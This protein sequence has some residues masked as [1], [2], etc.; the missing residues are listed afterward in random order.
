M[1]GTVLARTRV[2]TFLAAC[3]LCVSGAALA[4]GNHHAVDDAA[5]LSPGQCETEGWFE[6]SRSGVKLTHQGIGCRLGPVEV[7]AAGEYL[8]FAGASQTGWEVQLKWA[9]EFAP[10]LS[11]GVSMT[12]GW[13]ARARPRRQG[14]TVSGLFTWKAS[15]TLAAHINIGRDFVRG[16]GSL[17]RSGVSLEWSP[18]EKWM[19]V[20]ERYAQDQSQFLRA[21]VRW[22]ARENLS[23]DLSRAHRLSGPGESAWTFGT[24][25]LFEL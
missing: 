25:W 20:G 18:H 4:A 6:R 22:T 3:A 8:K 1:K 16:G 5:I 15:E 2:R 21:G 12:P 9:R 19:L 13:Q 23:V 11:A 24:T 17:N 7:G 14:T 10:G